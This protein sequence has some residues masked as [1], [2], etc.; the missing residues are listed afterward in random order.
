[1][2]ASPATANRAST[3]RRSSGRAATPTAASTRQTPQQQQRQAQ[4]TP[5]PGPVASFSSD[6]A[7]LSQ[8]ED[9]P[10]SASLRQRRRHTPAVPRTSVAPTPPTPA[11]R[12]ATAAAAATPTAQQRR[13][14]G[15]KSAALNTSTSLLLQDD[16]ESDAP[17]AAA[18]ANSAA[19]ASVSV[20][21]R[22]RDD[23]LDVSDVE[24]P[25]PVSAASRVSNGR[26]R[27]D[28]FPSTGGSVNNYWAMVPNF[29]LLGA[30]LLVIIIGGYF[31][32]EQNRL[33]KARQLEELQ[34]I[35]CPD[36]GIAAGGQKLECIPDQPGLMQ[37]VKLARP[38]LDQLARMRGDAECNGG[39]SNYRLHRQ[40]VVSLLTNS[41]SGLLVNETDVSNL[42]ALAIRAPRLGILALR[43]S[44]STDSDVVTKVED[45]GYLAAAEG[46]RS[47]SCRSRLLAWSA[48]ASIGR[49]AASLIYAA[50]GLAGLACLAYLL[51]YAVRLRRRRE[52]ALVDATD[53]VLLHLLTAE[54][55]VPVDEVRAELQRSGVLDS[56]NW[57]R[58]RER[59]VARERR[60]LIEESIRGGEVWRLRPGEAEALR[61]RGIGAGSA[62]GGAAAN[63]A[64]GGSA[65]VAR[66]WQGSVEPPTQC[67]KLRGMWSPDNGQCDKARLA[68]ELARKAPQDSILHVD[69]LA[70]GGEGFVY[71]L[72]RSKK[73]AGVT[74]NAVHAHF[75]DGTLV[76]ARYMTFDKYCQRFPEKVD[77]FKTLLGSN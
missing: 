20:G 38:L 56:V 17:D 23:R 29:M 16:S 71:A 54:S 65:G 32:T 41:V 5:P 2:N 40:S 9:R 63:F 73:D 22:R 67:L 62:V 42:I 53:Q 13:S 26:R 25:P 66:G 59:I 49:L 55:G 77:E 6:E 47:I 4:R 64:S 70:M 39:E 36:K 24:E 18:A 43:D 52:A 57:D 3:R 76:T 45:C 48:L 44:T 10:G 14:R 11:S 33:A 68:A 1:A 75:F 58:L 50:V 30:L 28:G 27:T 60:I 46:R 69:S 61:A 12:R 8:A 34:R 35:V 7:D 31:I 74:R 19:A 15:R 51:V 21:R 37:A 72:F